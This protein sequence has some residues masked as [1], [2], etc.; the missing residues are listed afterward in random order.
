VSDAGTLDRIEQYFPFG[1]RARLAG[2]DQLIQLLNQE[3]HNDRLYVALLQ[4]SPTMLVEDK[5]LPNVPLSEINVIGQRNPGRTTVLRQSELAERSVPMH[6]VITG[7]QYL[8]ITV[9]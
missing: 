7:H 1:P 6:E 5:R 8:T 9:K 4:S 3:R 2:L